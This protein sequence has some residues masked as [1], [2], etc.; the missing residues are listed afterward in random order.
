[1]MTGNELENFLMTLPV[2]LLHQF[3]NWIIEELIQP[4]LLTLLKSLDLDK[5]IEELGD[6][7][8]KVTLYQQTGKILLE[9][10]DLRELKDKNGDDYILLSQSIYVVYHLSNLLSTMKR[11]IQTAVMLANISRALGHRDEDKIV[12]QL[13]PKLRELCA[14][15]DIPLDID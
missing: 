12:P 9:L 4:F 15:Y 3:Y 11:N 5:Y 7:R 10:M 8:D 14:V 2:S 13:L 1:M 6:F